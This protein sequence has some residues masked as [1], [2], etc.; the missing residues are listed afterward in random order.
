MWS[1]LYC[2]IATDSL[3]LP[4]QIGVLDTQWG[5]TLEMRGKLVLH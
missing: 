3:M 1:M 4:G 2:K 5:E